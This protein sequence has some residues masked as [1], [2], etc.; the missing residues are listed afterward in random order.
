MRLS[1]LFGEPVIAGAGRRILQSLAMS[2]PGSETLR[3]RLHRLRGVQ[4]GSP[5]FIGSYTLIETS[6][7]ELV[8]IGNGV[9]IG[10]RVTIIAHFR[11]QSRGDG[12]VIEDEASIGPG[13]IIMPNVTIGYGAVV[14][15]GSVVTRSVPPLT[16]VQGNPAKPVAR[17]GVPLGLKT[18]YREFQRR[19]R[20][21]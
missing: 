11:D 20:P 5:C 2:A 12:V 13:S 15:A 9:A 6:H 19:L 8:K 18:P 16:L 14:A 1:D 4:I 7:P 21:L 17:C 10:M 3:V